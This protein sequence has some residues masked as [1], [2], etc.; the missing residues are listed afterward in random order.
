M[1]NFRQI[2]PVFAAKFYG[3][4]EDVEAPSDESGKH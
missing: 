4:F 2:V 3:V 1:T